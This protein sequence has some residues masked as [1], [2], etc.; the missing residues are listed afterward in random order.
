MNNKYVRLDQVD[1][2]NLSVKELV[3]FLEKVIDLKLP[4]IKLV[5]ENALERV[6]G[7]E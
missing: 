2:N 5:L 7:N 1:V 3:D 6:N 4:F